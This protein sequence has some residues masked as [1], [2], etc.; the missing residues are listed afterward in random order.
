MKQFLIKIFRDTQYVAYRFANIKTK[1]DCFYY[2]HDISEQKPNGVGRIT[3]N[4]YTFNSKTEYKKRCSR[5]HRRVNH[6]LMENLRPSKTEFLNER[7]AQ[8]INRLMRMVKNG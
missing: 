7:D 5:C 4:I 3:D 8:I 2:G 6:C 1:A